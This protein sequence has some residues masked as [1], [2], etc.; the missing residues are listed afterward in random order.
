M[1]IILKVLIT[2]V[3]LFLLTCFAG[4]M[5]IGSPSLQAGLKLLSFSF[6]AAALLTVLVGIWTF[7][8]MS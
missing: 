7:K 1:P 6:L 8:E 3:V 2:F 5:S 4:L